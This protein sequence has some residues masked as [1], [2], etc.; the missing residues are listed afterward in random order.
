M[1]WPDEVQFAMLRVE[2]RRRFQAMID[3]VKE[4]VGPGS[5]YE[6]D[7]V[8]VVISERGCYYEFCDL[9]EEFSGAVGQGFR[10]DFVGSAP[11]WQLLSE[12]QELIATARQFADESPASRL[13]LSCFCGSDPA[14]LWQV[15][16]IS[17]L[18]LYNRDGLFRNDSTYIYHFDA[19]DQE[20]PFPLEVG[21]YCPHALPVFFKLKVDSE[22][23][24]PL[25]GADRGIIFFVANLGDQH[26][27]VRVPHRMGVADLAEL[28]SQTMH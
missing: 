11:A 25:L 13:P 24:R 27:I 3:Y 8:R 1:S 20:D 22:L 6:N 15:R 18:A 2:A 17:F 12:I 14:Q 19:D 26:L 16:E 7:L 28:S 5:V 9:P 23:A 21:S 4:Q 10:A